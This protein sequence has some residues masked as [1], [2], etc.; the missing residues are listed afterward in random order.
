MEPVEITAG[1]LHLRPWRGSDADDVLRACSDPLV[2]RWTRVPVPYTAEHAR[3]Y[4]AAGAR[5]GDSG[6]ELQWAVCDSTTGGLLASVVLR[7]GVAEGL[8]EVGYWAVP[9]A[10]GEGVVPQAVG[11]AC[12]YAHAQPALEVARVEWVAA[13]T[14][15]ASRRAA[16]K[17]GFT[18]EGVLRAGAEQRGERLDAWLGARLPGDPDRDTAL[19]APLGRPHD[20]VVALRRWVEHDVNA[21]RR[22]C[23]DPL[24]AR[25]LPLPV[26]YT[27]QAARDWLL[28]AVPQAWLDGTRA[29]VAVVD[30]R[31]GELLGAAGLGLATR[32]SGTE[33]AATWSSSPASQATEPVRP[34]V[35]GDG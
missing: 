3:A 8:W 17:A 1:R 21:V 12:R 24:T 33:R 4:V 11:V 20:G 26:P 10:R 16:E 29:E 28:D 6:R 34:R 25:H 13:R 9:K 32:A 18:G 27:E 19:L 14:N 7:P 31:T 2:Q 22:A 35:A 15:F 23:D 5:G 30:D